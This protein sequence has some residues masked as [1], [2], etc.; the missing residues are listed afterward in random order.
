MRI[1]KIVLN[2]MAAH[3]A[4]MLVVSIMLWANAFTLH[5]SEWDGAARI[6]YLIFIGAYYVFLSE[7]V[8][9]KEKNN[10]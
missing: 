6:L 4:M 8:Y 7:V 5:P 2:M 10:D 3:I 1:L 9:F